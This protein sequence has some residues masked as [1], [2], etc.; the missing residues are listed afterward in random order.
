MQFA[1][2]WH[3]KRRGSYRASFLTYGSHP[4]ISPPSCERSGSKHV[5]FDVACD[6]FSG[7]RAAFI[8][9]HMPDVYGY[10]CTYSPTIEII[11]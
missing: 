5:N 9:L 7:E 2:A 1:C 8:M 3:A 4:A 10:K 6:L 11:N